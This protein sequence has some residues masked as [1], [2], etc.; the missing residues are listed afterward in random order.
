MIGVIAEVAPEEHSA[1]VSSPQR[2]AQV[3]GATGMDGVDS[4][5]ACFGR[6]FGK[7]F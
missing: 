6:R 4:E 1:E 7:G 3:A 2:Q 5:A